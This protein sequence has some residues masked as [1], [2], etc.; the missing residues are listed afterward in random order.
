[1]TLGG[2]LGVQLMEI[3]KGRKPMDTDPTTEEGRRFWG[4]AFVRSGGAG[5][6]FDVVM[7]L[8]DYRQGI[9]GYVA[10]PVLG[11]LDSI[12]YALFGSAKDAIEGKEDAG[13]KF[14]TRAMKEVIG[15]TPYQSNWMINLVMKRLL[16]EKILLW[17]DP[18]Y[19]KEINRSM[20]RDYREG[21]EYWWK[22]SEDRPRE[23]PFD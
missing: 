21:K 3:T 16:W 23:N 11:S 18:A 22:P 10:G 13:A 4:N 7:G 1:M 19:I 20:R 12:G 9:S 5:P 14:K 8:G 17:N 6:L 2:A 15:H